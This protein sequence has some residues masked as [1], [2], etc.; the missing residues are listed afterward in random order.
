MFLKSKQ[1]G[2]LIQIENLESLINPNENQI[3]GRDQAGQEEQ[4]PASYQK[5]ELIFPS[6]EQLPRCWLDANYPKA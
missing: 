6:G 3:T 2:T 1:N 4:G 5:E